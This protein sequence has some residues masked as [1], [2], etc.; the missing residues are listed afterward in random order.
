MQ[1][2]AVHDHERYSPKHLKQIQPLCTDADALVVTSKD[3]VKLCKLI[4][5]TNWSIPIIV[6]RLELDVFQGETA[7]VNVIQERISQ[8][9]E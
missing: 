6:R 8:R 3:W 5:L 9:V 1:D 7:L 4:D 2:I